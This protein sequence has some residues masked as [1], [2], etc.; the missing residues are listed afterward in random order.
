MNFYN[1]IELRLSEHVKEQ[2]NSDNNRI[3]RII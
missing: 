1:K 2:D 3:V